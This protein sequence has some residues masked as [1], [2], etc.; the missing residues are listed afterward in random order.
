MRIAIEAKIHHAQQQRDALRAFE[1]SLRTQE[2][3]CST[4]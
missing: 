3:D 4:L 1:A 2:L